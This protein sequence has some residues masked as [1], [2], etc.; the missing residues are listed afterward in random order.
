[1]PDS[2]ALRLYS[3]GNLYPPSQLSMYG[4][5]FIVKA[6]W[7][8]SLDP[9]QDTIDMQHFLTLLKASHETVTVTVDGKQQQELALYVDRN[10]SAPYVGEGQSLKT[11][12]DLSLMA[13][14][15]IG[16]IRNSAII[17]FVPN[18]FI[19]KP[20][21]VQEGA[22][23]TPMK[24]LASANNM[25]I[26]DTTDYSEEYTAGTGF[27]ASMTAL[28][29]SLQDREHPLELTLYFKVADTSDDYTLFLKHWKLDRDIRL[30][31]TINGD[32]ENSIVKY[33]DALEAEGGENNILAIA[34]RD[35][36]YASV[37]YHDYLKLGLNA[38]RV[39]IQP[40]DDKASAY[41]VRA[42]SIEKS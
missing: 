37:N 32:E 19:V 35:L 2:V 41:Q 28:N 25:L 4:I 15:P 33:V 14:D 1:M 26:K 20:S 23:A 29:A 8:F 5:N 18:K 24:I 21:P 27:K 3:E 12:L 36:N 22:P 40:E 7:L 39:K 13:M 42:I 34:L 10:A 17:G 11:S 6:K 9:D 38:I 31:F 16:A 30:T